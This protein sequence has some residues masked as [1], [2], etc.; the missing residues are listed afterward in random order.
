MT[1]DQ[2]S[3]RVDEHLIAAAPDLPRHEAAGELADALNA[4]GET[5][6]DP[7]DPV[8]RY[9]E[10]TVA[11]RVAEDD[12]SIRAHF[13]PRDETDPAYPSGEH[14]RLRAYLRGESSARDAAR[15][16]ATFFTFDDVDAS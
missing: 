1:L 13:V 10:R 8:W 9:R 11:M 12:A 14:S 16:I 5:R 2:W 15:D 3:A 6:F 7:D 4:G